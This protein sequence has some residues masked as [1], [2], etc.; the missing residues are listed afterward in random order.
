LENIIN[1][2]RLR[3]T[4]VD[5]LNDP[6]EGDVLYTRL[7]KA[8]E[9]SPKILQLLKTVKKGN[10]NSIAF[11][12]SFTLLED[13]ISM[14]NSSYAE[15]GSGVAI[16]IKKEKMY[17]G[18]G[19]EKQISTVP[20]SQEDISYLSDKECEETSGKKKKEIEEGNKNDL[21]NYV[22]VSNMGLYEIIYV[23]NNTNDKPNKMIDDIANCLMNIPDDDLSDASF[24]SLLSELLLSI[25]HIIKDKAYEHE[26]E[27]RLMYIG[28]IQEDQ[29]HIHSTFNDGI[30]IE[31]DSFLF[32]QDDENNIICFGPN[33]SLVKQEKI[34]HFMKHKG[35][36]A[37]IKHSDAPFRK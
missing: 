28:S 20:A 33:V 21:L 9:N 36:F 25:A 7:S 31:T 14:W 1:N 2:Q 16:G 18:F 13:N 27:Y 29:H 24:I 26:K 34:A 37:T 11:V 15:N 10:S 19:L 5:Y 4:P 35:L 23:D 6:L 8:V 17:A 3:L 30:F 32:K 22:P 12:R